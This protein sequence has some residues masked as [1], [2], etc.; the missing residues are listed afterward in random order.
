M[1][2]E[3]VLEQEVWEAHG[4]TLHVQVAVGHGLG[5]LLGGIGLFLRE[6]HAHRD[7][8]VVAAVAVQGLDGFRGLLSVVH[9]NDGTAIGRRV[10]L[11]LVRRGQN[12]QPLHC[13]ELAEQRADL[14]LRGRA[15]EAFHI[16]MVHL[17]LSALLLQLRLERALELLVDLTIE[18]RL[19]KSCLLL[20]CHAHQRRAR[21]H[22]VPTE[23]SALHNLPE[24]SEGGG[25][26]L[27][28]DGR[29]QVLDV[30]VVA[31]RS[32]ALRAGVVAITRPRRTLP[33]PGA[34]KEVPTLATALATP[35]IAA[36][37]AGKG[38]PRALHDQIVFPVQAGDT[39]P[40]GSCGGE[41]HKGVMLFRRRVRLDGN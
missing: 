12:A 5:F 31:G 22:A 14:I 26:L 4:P 9:L 6:A 38:I 23:H 27:L 29:R 25:H 11:R 33:E 17:W 7:T 34:G 3:G 41:L 30:K 16:D 40:S 1:L 10:V 13:A 20:R 37:T 18:L 39:T 35:P 28:C 24:L 21:G 36:K 32:F 15:M 19:R 8:Q 2:L